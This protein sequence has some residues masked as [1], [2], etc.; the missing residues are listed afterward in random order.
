[1]A[2]HVAKPGGD[3]YDPGKYMERGV[4]ARSEHRL[5]PA[6]AVVGK[7]AQQPLQSDRQHRNQHQRQPDRA[8]QDGAHRRRQ[9]L[10]NRLDGG[11][12]HGGLAS[13]EKTLARGRYSQ[14]LRQE[15]AGPRRNKTVVKNRPY[16]AAMT[17]VQELYPDN[18]IVLREVGLRDGL[19]L[20]KTFPSTSAKQRWIRDEYAAG[21]RHF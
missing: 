12:Q 14:G 3:R 4:E 21:V 10:R 20:V 11:V 16:E 5:L 15:P 7:P 18:K 6:L 19:Q 1:A 17:R 2:E 8:P 13:C 9:D